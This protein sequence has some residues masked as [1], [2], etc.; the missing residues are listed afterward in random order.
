MVCRTVLVTDVLCI[1]FFIRL[2]QNLPSRVPSAPHP[3]H[4]LG[5]GR[6]A[7]GSSSPL[8]ICYLV[9]AGSR[10][11]FH[12]SLCRVRTLDPFLTFILCSS[13]EKQLLPR[14]GK[15][16]VTPSITMGNL[17]E[18]IWV[19]TPRVIDLQD[20]PHPH[21]PSNSVVFTPSALSLEINHWL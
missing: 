7:G 21:P 16:D 9:V 2:H 19:R 3:R 13:V 6:G 20:T 12:L 15:K 5:R 10:F 11:R 1:Y 18:M 14:V 17:A 4:V 8:H